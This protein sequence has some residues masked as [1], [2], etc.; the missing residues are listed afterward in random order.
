MDPGG[1][2]P[3]PA[4]R[5][6][7]QH[8]F[9]DGDSVAPCLILRMVTAEC[10]EDHNYSVLRRGAST[11]VGAFPPIAAD[12]RH[13]LALSCSFSEFHNLMTEFVSLYSS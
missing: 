13:T 8:S 6:V 12:V 7:L 4:L 11:T 9:L 10:R 2:A 1:L 3:E 5:T